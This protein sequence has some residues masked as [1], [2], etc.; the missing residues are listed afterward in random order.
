MTRIFASNHNFQQ[1]DTPVADSGENFKGIVI[2]NNIWVGAGCT[3]LDGAVL[4]DSSVYGANSIIS[5]CYE[6]RTRNL[7]K[8]TKAKS[9]A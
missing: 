6:P 8:G 7:A 5:G 1:N 2:G 4:G 9:L 3:I